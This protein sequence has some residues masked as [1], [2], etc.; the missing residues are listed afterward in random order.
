M[1]FSTPQYGH[2][3]DATSL[4]DDARRPQRRAMSGC[5]AGVFGLRVVPADVI[6]RSEDAHVDMHGRR[7]R[8]VATSSV[9]VHPPTPARALVASTVPDGMVLA[10][11]WKRCAAYIVDV[12]AINAVL[13]LITGGSFVLFQYGFGLIVDAGRDDLGRGPAGVTIIIALHWL[14]YLATH[15]LYF[16]YTGRS[17]GRSLGQRWFALAVVHDDGSPLN[18]VHWGPRARSKFRYVIPIVGVLLGML[19]AVTIHRGE[20]HRTGVDMRNHTIVALERTLPASTRH[21]LR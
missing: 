14:I 10:P 19:D 7:P 16:K 8:S 15:F 12:V 17:M 21:V 5:A 9:T 3:L 4:S 6:H 11:S 2:G 18:D 13:N 1:G 20:D